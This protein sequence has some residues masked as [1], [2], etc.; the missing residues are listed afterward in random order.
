M[1]G[2]I[3][4]IKE[5]NYQLKMKPKELLE[6]FGYLH[7]SEVEKMTF[8][9]KY[10]TL[11]IKLDDFYANFMDLPEYKDLKKVYFNINLDDKLDINI[12]MFK[13]ITLNIYEIKIQEEFLEILLSPSGFIKLSFRK[14]FL[15]LE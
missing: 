10:M 5:L 3:E 13:D 6:S 7:D 8:D 4:L 12:D 2:K 11:K 1:R 15:S 9:F 14:L